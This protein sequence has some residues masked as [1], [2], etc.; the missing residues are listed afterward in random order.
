MVWPYFC[1]GEHV[2]TT[3]VRM[4]R[5]SAHAHRLHRLR[6][7]SRLALANLGTA[8]TAAAPMYD[9]QAFPYVGTTEPLGEIVRPETQVTSLR[10]Y[11]VFGVTWVNVTGEIV[12]PEAQTRG[13]GNKSSGHMSSE[14]FSWVTWVNVTGEI[15]RPEAQVT[16]LFGVTWGQCDL[17][18]SD[19]TYGRAGPCDLGG[20]RLVGQAAHCNIRLPQRPALPAGAWKRAPATSRLSTQPPF[21]GLTRP[22]AAAAAS[23]IGTACSIG[24][25][26]ASAATLRRGME[27]WKYTRSSTSPSACGEVSVFDVVDVLTLRVAGR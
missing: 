16:S 6:D 20:P 25:P 11:M 17:G 10:V 15:V 7:G 8:D 18:S 26:S 13:P 4:R 27:S 22:A 19:W 14:Q 5:R 1:H 24:P 3:D 2:L 9:V 21:H 23:E 12:R